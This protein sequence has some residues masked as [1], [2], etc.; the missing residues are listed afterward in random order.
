MSA[1]VSYASGDPSILEKEF[2]LLQGTE[3]RMPSI[4]T[5]SESTTLWDRF[6]YTIQTVGALLCRG[7][8]LVLEWRRTLLTLS[9]RGISRCVKSSYLA[10][11]MS[12]PTWNSQSHGGH[13]CLINIGG[14]PDASGSVW[15]QWILL[16][17]SPSMQ[18]SVQPHLRVRTA[19]APREDNITYMHCILLTLNSHLDLH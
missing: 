19:H 13:S 15:T 4:D 7:T 2:H 6:L 18:V 12:R 9:H 16:P 17:A 5:G 11:L 10:Q 1:H 3:L 8:Y 14:S